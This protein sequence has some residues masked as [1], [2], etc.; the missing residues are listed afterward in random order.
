[1]VV[2]T[3]A[4]NYDGVKFYH[5][6]Q[7]TGMFQ[8]CYDTIPTVGG[9]YA[10]TYV[11]ECEW[12]SAGWD[13]GEYDLIAI[14]VIDGAENASLSDTVTV[15]IDNT[16]PVV[17]GTEPVYDGGYAGVVQVEFSE[18]MKNSTVKDLKAMFQNQTNMA[19]IN[20]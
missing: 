13:D 16:C 4:S 14:P 19:Y 20:L 17:V 2:G 11:Y 8:D 7:G 3:E 9:P 1:M 6:A 10:F 5:Q 18:S 12:Q 15:E